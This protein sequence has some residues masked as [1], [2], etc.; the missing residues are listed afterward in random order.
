MFYFNGGYFCICWIRPIHWPPFVLGNIKRGQCI[1]LCWICSLFACDVNKLIFLDEKM[2]PDM[3]EFYLSVQPQYTQ[4]KERVITT[5]RP[6]RQ[7]SQSGTPSKS[8]HSN[9]KMPKSVVK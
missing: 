6:L 8:A 3:K 9:P 4:K 5:T 7:S 1:G 2:P